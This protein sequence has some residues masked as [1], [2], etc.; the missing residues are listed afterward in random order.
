MTR[1]TDD[2]LMAEF[3]AG[4]QSA[5][6]RLVGRYDN[7]L[8]GWLVRQTGCIHAAEDLSQETWMRAARSAARY[9]PRGEFRAWLF[10]MARNALVDSSRK[11]KRSIPTDNR[12]RPVESVSREPDP[13]ELA[14]LHDLIE[15]KN[16]AMELIPVD[17]RQTLES[18]YEGE[19]LPDIAYATDSLLPTTKSRLRLA[20]EKLIAAM[21]WA[22]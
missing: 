15:I 20:R 22:V 14:E 19:S 13:A 7:Q 2:C 12:P 10:R 4:S 1:K 17:Q 9:E 21:E 3:K 16:R 11:A 18:Y 6:A 5:F 8:S